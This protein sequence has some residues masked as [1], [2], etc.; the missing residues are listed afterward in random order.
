[1]KRLNAEDPKDA[2]ERG[3]AFHRAAA[4]GTSEKFITALA[5]VVRKA[6]AGESTEV[7]RLPEQELQAPTYP[8]YE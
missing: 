2:E 1:M 7:A 8:T 6:E 5:E 4:L 3:L